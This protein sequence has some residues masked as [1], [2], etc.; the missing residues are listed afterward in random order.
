MKRS[1]IVTFA[2]AGAL[3]AAS[4]LHAG[5]TTVNGAPG[6]ELG[7]R[8]I[9][10][11]IYGG[12]FAGGSLD[13]SM[14]N[15]SVTVTR[16]RDYGSSALDAGTLPFNLTDPAGSTAGLATDQILQGESLSFQARARYAGFEQYLGMRSGAA[17]GGGAT[18]LLQAQ[19]SGF[20]DGS[21]AA[22]TAAALL[23][24]GQ[25]FRFIRASN[26]A[27]T[28]HAWSSAAAD[29]VDGADHMIAYRVTGLGSEARYL[30]F[31]EDLGNGTAR[32]A[33]GS[34][35]SEGW[36]A[37]YNDFVVEMVAVPAPGAL[38]LLAAVALP[39]MTRRRRI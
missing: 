32:T 33:D 5:F 22:N 34:I 37:D 12:S 13:G 6:G 11:G 2:G 1:H 38:A 19:G 18:L 16:V 25:D 30:L 39:V 14:S 17:G 10:A 23:S 9:L 26:S 36:D 29:N 35:V 27:F 21:N 8:D 15:G 28:E 7:V 31:W 3:G 24:P 20:L 4:L